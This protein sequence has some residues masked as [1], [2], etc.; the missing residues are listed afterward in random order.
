M[1]KRRFFQRTAE[2]PATGKTNRQQFKNF[3]KY[4]EM[5]QAYIKQEREIIPKAVLKARRMLLNAEPS[6][7]L[8][9]LSVERA[10]AGTAKLGDLLKQIDKTIKNGQDAA[11]LPLGDIRKELLEVRTARNVI[12]KKM[13]TTERQI[14]PAFIKHLQSKGY[15]K[16]KTS[17]VITEITHQMRKYRHPFETAYWIALRIVPKK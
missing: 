11:R 15:S 14:K 5:H 6:A 9:G 16:E 17:Q 12:L 7:A 13:R 4:F 8:L 1:F 3:E 2:K 10:V